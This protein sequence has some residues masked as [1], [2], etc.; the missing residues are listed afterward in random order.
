MGKDA[1]I[2]SIQTKRPKGYAYNITQSRPSKPN[3]L[4]AVSLTKGDILVLKIISVRLQLLFSSEEI[5]SVQVEFQ[6]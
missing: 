6:F 2:Y 4:V 5:I 1:K 3:Q